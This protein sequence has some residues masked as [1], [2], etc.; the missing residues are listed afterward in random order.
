MQPAGQSPQP[1]STVTANPPAAGVALYEQHW[2]MR[3]GS[4]RSIPAKRVS[5]ARTTVAAASGVLIVVGAGAT[6]A[7]GPGR[8]EG[9]GV[10]EGAQAP[11]S[12]AA[13]P[14]ARSA[15]NDGRMRTG[16][17]MALRRSWHA[18]GSARRLRTP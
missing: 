4:A 17:F 11:R 6:E 10:A 5:L 16:G 2:P 7:D 1:I 9:A 13:S 18:P 14:N 8:T 15:S 12:P 3:F